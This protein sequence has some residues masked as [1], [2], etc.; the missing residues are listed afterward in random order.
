MENKQFLIR[1]AN[2]LDV[3]NKQ[4]LAYVVRKNFDEFLEMLEN[5][6]IDFDMEKSDLNPRDT[7]S[8][9]GITYLH[10]I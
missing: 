8:S 9:G 7:F 5:G 4:D 1:L 3:E 2:Q 10:E 6:E